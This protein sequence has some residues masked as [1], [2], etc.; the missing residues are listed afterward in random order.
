MEKGKIILTSLI[1]AILVFISVYFVA[2]KNILNKKEVKKFIVD[3]YLSTEKEI[4]SANP[5]VYYFT[6]D[7]Y[8]VYYKGDYCAKEN[9]ELISY[10][11]KYTIENGIL[12]LNI[13]SKT[14]T[15]NGVLDEDNVEENCLKDYEE[16]IINEKAIKKLEFKEFIED[17]KKDIGIKFNNLELYKL[18][19]DTSKVKELLKKY[20]NK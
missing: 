5:N 6:K 12:K 17:D 2:D 8:F 4:G 1:G 16:K 14:V 3:S 20:K 7:G 11:G 13:I 9:N 10:Y 15:D 18:S 19:G